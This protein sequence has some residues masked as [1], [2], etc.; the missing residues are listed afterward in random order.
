MKL[1]ARSHWKEIS[2]PRREGCSLSN[3]L[4]IKN[5]FY[6]PYLLFHVFIFL[7]SLVTSIDLVDYCML[8]CFLCC[9]PSFT[10]SSVRIARKKFE[11]STMAFHSIDEPDLGRV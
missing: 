8:S 3:H 10:G 6:F 5:V 7:D 11:R 1:E 4:L 2:T 9:L